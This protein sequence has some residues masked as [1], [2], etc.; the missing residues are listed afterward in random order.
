MWY[1]L[2]MTTNVNPRG[3]LRIQCA[4]TADRQHAAAAHRGSGVVTVEFYDL[5][6]TGEDGVFSF[7]REFRAFAVGD[8]YPAEVPQAD[9]ERFLARWVR[10]DRARLPGLKAADA[11]EAFPTL[12]Y[13][14]GDIA[15][16]PLDRLRK[17][18][19]EA[20]GRLEAEGP[21]IAPTAAQVAALLDNRVLLG[22]ASKAAL[23][24]RLNQLRA[25]EAYVNALMNSEPAPLKAVSR[26]MGVDPVQARNLI[27]FARANDY[28]EGKGQGQSK[29]RAT[30]EA[31]MLSEKAKAEADRLKG[32]QA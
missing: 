14:R 10:S 29:G 3:P 5:L 22:Y 4:F 32:A 1:I 25:V 16:A 19:D 21:F 30:E 6:D 31:R 12:H 24:S 18:L 27:Q 11:Q 26:E 13:A 17:A 2:A 9:L 23:R 15:R 8:D 28:M 7:A 20:Y